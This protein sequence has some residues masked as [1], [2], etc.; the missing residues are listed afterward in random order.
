MQEN[1]QRL[2]W[3]DAQ[4]FPDDT[5]AIIPGAM[6]WLAV[7]GTEIVAYCALRVNYESRTPV[8]YLYRAGVMPKYRGRGLQRKMIDIR[9][10]AA[11]KLK[12][13]AVVTVTAWNN[14]AS[15]RSLMA[16]GFKPF[17]PNAYN[18]IL[19]TLVHWRKE[20]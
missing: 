9:C 13:K 19:E 15:M 11:K 14:V 10:K 2:V 12:L 18:I 20:I 4:C 6:W 17:R 7:D 8:G 1:H 3:A 5:P 16:T